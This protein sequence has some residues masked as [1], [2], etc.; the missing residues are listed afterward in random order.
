MPNQRTFC[1]IA[2]SN[3]MPGQAP[4][5]VALAAQGLEALDL[6][7]KAELEPLVALAAQGLEAPLRHPTAELGLPPE[8]LAAHSPSPSGIRSLLPH[9]RSSRPPEDHPSLG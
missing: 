5:E 7:P 9:R 8:P 1:H 6:H 4:V 2:W 3:P